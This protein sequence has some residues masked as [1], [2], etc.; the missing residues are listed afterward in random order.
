MLLR[1]SEAVRSAELER[2][3]DA[4]CP[5]RC[6]FRRDLLTPVAEACLVE[7]DVFASEFVIRAYRDSL[8]VVEIPTRVMEKRPPTINLM[9]RVPNV[10]RSIV[11]LT[12]AIRVRG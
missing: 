4:R 8:C 11:K 9:K 5:D 2:F 6:T 3:V 7:K 12:W 10:L 1:I